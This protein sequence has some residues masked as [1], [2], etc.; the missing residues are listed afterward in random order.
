MKK[1]T[2]LLSAMLL[3]SSISFAQNNRTV[4]KSIQTGASQEVLEQTESHLY[5]TAERTPDGKIRCFSQQ[6]DQLLRMKHP[7]LGSQEDFENWIAPKIEEWKKNSNNNKVV[8]TIPVVVHVVHNGDPVGSSENISAAAVQSQIDV[9]NDDFR[10]IAGS[11]GDGAGVD[12]EIEFCLALTDPQ[13]NPMAEPG[14]DRYNGGQASWTSMG[15]IDGT[16]KPATSWDPTNYF[17]M[18]TVNF[19]GTGL[20]GYAQ[21]P[22][23]SGLPGLNTNNGAANTDGVVIGY[24]YFGSID[25]GISG[26]SSPYNLGRTASHE[27]GHCFGL[28]HIWGDANCGNDYCADTPESTTS[29]Y[30]CPNQTTCDGIQDQVENYM[31]Y[32]NDACMDMFTQNQKDRILTVMS[33]S[34]RRNTLPSSTA[35][36]VAAINADFSASTTSINAGQSVTFTDASTSPNTLNGWTWNFDVTGVGGA[37]PSTASTQGPH[38]VTYNTAGT[39]TVSLAVTDNAAGNDSETKTAYI[40]VNPAGTVTCDS[41]AAGWDWAN[42]QFFTGAYWGPDCNGPTANSGYIMGNNCYDDNGWASKVSFSGSGKE[43]TDLI[44]L[45]DQSTG[46]GTGDLKVWDA[47]GAAGAPNTVL[48]SEAITTGQFSGSLQQ[49]LLFPVSPAVAVTGDFFIGNDH[50]VVPIDGDTLCMAIA[51]GTTGNQVWAY[52]ISGSWVDLSTYGVDYKGTVGVV[53]CD[54][55]SGVKSHL[56]NINE[57]LVYPNPTT[58]EIKIL[59]PNKVNSSVSVFNVIGEKVYNVTSNS[60]YIDFDLSK[61]PNGVYF[62]KVT[63]NGEVTTKKILLSK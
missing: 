44:Y 18:W 20:L 58:G 51:A 9:L 41:T 33:N 46:T 19:G 11:R 16:L 28:R 3:I 17:N 26:L 2:Y 31:D 29:N 38:V 39:F 56:A 32:T 47:D 5:Q 13:G 63:S 34:P 27:V 61:Q 30:G 6:A 48:F 10:K 15:T 14:I 52:E 7:E 59:L 23:S 57:T 22:N 49:L 53:I 54:I 35:C 62:V 36:G 25:D 12:V 4:A 40:T 50:S 45:F 21:F 37:T 8:L 60:N 55:S 24:N 43:I 1:I 42:E